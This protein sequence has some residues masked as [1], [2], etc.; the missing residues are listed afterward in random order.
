[1]DLTNGLRVAE[2]GPFDRLTEAGSVGV[3]RFFEREKLCCP[4]HGSEPLAVWA[5]LSM[6]PISTQ[7]VDG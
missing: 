7:I 5:V 4:N 1:M 2:S 6:R 3:Q